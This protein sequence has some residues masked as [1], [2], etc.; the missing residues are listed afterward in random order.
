MMSAL[1][2]VPFDIKQGGGV[3]P[4]SRSRPLEHRRA[5]EMDTV[6]LEMTLPVGSAPP[7]RFHYV[8]SMTPGNPSRARWWWAPRRRR[9]G[10]RLLGNGSPCPGGEPGTRSEVVG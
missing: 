5:P 6:V 8:T 10:G 7:L 9:A 4:P 2:H 3:A 1:G